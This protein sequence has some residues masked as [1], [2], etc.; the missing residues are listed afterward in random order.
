MASYLITGVSRGIGFAFLRQLSENP[1]NTIVGLVRD[2][3]STDK[4][5]A[6]ELSDRKNITILQADVN[7]YAALKASV[8]ETSKITGGSLDYIIANAAWMSLWSGVETFGDLGAEPEKLENELLAAYR[9]NVVGSVHLFNLYTP[10]ILKGRVKKVIAISTGM[11]DAEVTAKWDLATGGP[12]SASKAALNM[13]VAKFSAEYKEQG[14]L[15][16]AVSPGVVET[17]GYANMTPEQGLKAQKMF[18]KFAAYA[19]DFAGPISP[20]ESA[21]LVLSVIEKSSIENGN[22]GD[23]LSHKGDKSWL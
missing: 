4:K 10:L 1:A 11:A 12:Y 2:K 14:V 15:F 18:G 13:V 8:A 23:F 6:S 22:G 9:T 19:P 7:D 5:V 17:G 16:L 20:E 3:A 21:K